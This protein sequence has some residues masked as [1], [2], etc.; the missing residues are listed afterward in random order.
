MNEVRFPSA[1]SILITLMI[2]SGPTSASEKLE[3][4]G[5]PSHDQA[6]T[7]AVS[8][9]SLIKFKLLPTQKI[10][11]QALKT[12]GAIDSVRML[13]AGDAELAILP[14]VVGHGARLGIGSF[15]G[16]PPETGFR[17]IATLWQDALHLVVR[18]G[19]VTTGTIDD[20]ARLKDPKVYL[21]ENSSGVVDINRLLFKDLGMDVDRTFVPT[22]IADGDGISA[23]KR[24]D[25]D[26]ISATMRPPET[27]FNG[28]FEGGDSGLRLLD[29]TE[30]QLIR[31]NSN[32]WLWT[33]YVIP[34]DTYPGQNEDIWTIATANHLVARADVDS[35]V[36]YAVTKS[37]FENLAYLKRVDPL[38]ADLS[39]ESALAGMAMPL[40]PGALRYYEEVG[41]IS[42]SAPTNSSP[43]QKLIPVKKEEER[44]RM[45]PERYPD[46]DVAGEWPAGVGGPLLRTEPGESAPK[47]I[48]K[49]TRP[50]PYWRHRATL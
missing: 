49:K 45:A 46:A 43:P 16:E 42:R 47:S 8:L 5:G 27:M 37:M 34:A 35:D 13:Q 48:D 15:A 11:L 4:A 2:G 14:A 9:S 19:D 36:I 12:S 22:P 50:N 40:H 41:L 23:M 33:P 29:V 6:Y 39:L 7:A 18:E 38:M 10:D 26:A 17:A 31:A 24:G 20:L 1:A 30:N 44:P 21:G 3:L 28:A 32:H 25:V